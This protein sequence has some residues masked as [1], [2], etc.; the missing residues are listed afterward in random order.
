MAIICSHFLNATVEASNRI[1]LEV[2][3]NKECKAYVEKNAEKYSELLK[4]IRDAKA[5]P[6]YFAKRDIYK[7]LLEFDGAME[8]VFDPT[9]AKL[10]GEGNVP[11]KTP[12][13]EALKTIV[14]SILKNY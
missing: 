12:I 14:D 5:K 11:T 7:L 6:N 8:M 2:Y 9:L 13:F 10:M 1:Q 4:L 3:N